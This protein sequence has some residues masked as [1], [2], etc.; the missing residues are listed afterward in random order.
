MKKVTG[1]GGVFFK[2]KNVAAINEWYRDN[3]GFKTSQWGASIPWNDID[4]SNKNV[5]TTVWNPFKEDSDYYAPS[6]LPYMINYRVED[7]KSLIDTLRSEGVKIVGELSEYDY[8]KFAHIMDNEGRKIELWEPIYGENEEAPAAWNE[9]VIGLAGIT[10]KSADPEK[11]K[12]W[13]KKHLGI[14]N[15]FY[16]KDLDSNKSRKIDW[17]LSKKLE[18]DKPYA[19][20]YYAKNVKAKSTFSDPEENRVTLYPA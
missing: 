16:Y 9:N 18:G 5:G 2:A 17:L 1:I 10:L 13:Y 7:L 6:K 19:F 3:L 4:A 8:G 15:A 12:E 14:E 20:A 11:T